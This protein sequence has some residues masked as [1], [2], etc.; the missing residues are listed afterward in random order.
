MNVLCLVY[1]LGFGLVWLF[2]TRNQLPIALRIGASLL[3]PLVLVFFVIGHLLER[4]GD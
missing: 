2:E 3:W 4:G 1:G